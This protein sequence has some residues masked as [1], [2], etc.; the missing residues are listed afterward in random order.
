MRRIAPNSNTKFINSVCSFIEN[1]LKGVK[2]ES[3]YSGNEFIVN[4]KGGEIKITVP[5]DNEYS[6]TV[7]GRFSDVKKAK[8]LFSCNPYSGK[9]NTHISA[10]NVNEAIK[11]A[12]NFYRD[13]Q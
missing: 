9:Y 3:R 11:L 8:E 4:T 1:E 6:Y 10:I 12:K 5:T 13:M 2:C 7:F